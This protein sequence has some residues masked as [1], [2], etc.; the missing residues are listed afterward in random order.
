MSC[1]TSSRE[2]PWCGCGFISSPSCFAMNKIH[3]QLLSELSCFSSDLTEDPFLIVHYATSDVIGSRRFE[4]TYRHHLQVLRRRN[5]F[6][7][8]SNLEDEGTAI[9]QWSSIIRQRNGI[10]C[11]IYQNKGKE[12]VKIAVN[13]GGKE[14]RVTVKFGWKWLSALIVT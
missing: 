3:K 5:V 1:C 4:V 14:G 6:L 2:D 10:P 13:V 12:S 9:N 8:V 7:V 11:F